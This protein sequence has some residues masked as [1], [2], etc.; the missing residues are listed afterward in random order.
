MAVLAVAVGAWFVFKPEETRGGLTRDGAEELVRRTAGVR[1]GDCPDEKVL[2]AECEPARSGWFC[3][4]STR[5]SDGED[6]VAA[7]YVPTIGIV[8]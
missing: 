2:R 5:N 7:G 8:C 4:Y 6:F 3:E 1:A